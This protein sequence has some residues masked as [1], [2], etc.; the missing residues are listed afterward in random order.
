VLV[1]VLTDV[2][3][4]LPAVGA[5]LAAARDVIEH[6]VGQRVLGDVSDAP[7]AHPPGRL[8]AFLDGDHHDRLA[9]RAAA[10]GALAPRADVALIDLHG[11]REQLAAREDH[12]SAQLVQPCPGGLIAAQPQDSLKAERGDTLLLVDDV[13]DSPQPSDQGC[14]RARED[15][16]GCDRRLRA[17]LHAA[18]IPRVSEWLNTTGRVVEEQFGRR[19]LRWKRP[20]DTP[21]STSPPAG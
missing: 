9:D 20:A 8:A 6:E 13:P 2:K 12:R 19:G 17:A 16:A 14:A 15:R 3:V 1:A 7:H 18:E 21:L 4:A 10:T 11:A 5:N